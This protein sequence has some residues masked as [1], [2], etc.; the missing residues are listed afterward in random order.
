[1]LTRYITEPEN[2][3]DREILALYGGHSWQAGSKMY[4]GKQYLDD[5]QVLLDRMSS[6]VAE[7]VPNETFVPYL[8]T[9]FVYGSAIVTWNR[10]AAERYVEAGFRRIK[11]SRATDLRT[12]R[13]T[14]LCYNC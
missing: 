4:L 12:G 1:M 11:I 3:I 10:D 5:M 7:T 2:G 8:N 14:R 6:G 13:I 9:N